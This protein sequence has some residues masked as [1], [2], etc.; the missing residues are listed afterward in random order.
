MSMW[1]EPQALV[2][3]SQSPAGCALLEAAGIPLE[4]RPAQL[5]EGT[6]ERQHRDAGAGDL[7][8]LLARAKAAAV[9]PMMPGCL[10]LGADQVLGLDEKRFS[11]PVDRGAARDQLR[12]LRGRT[13]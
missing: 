2:L 13:H 3:A 8:A 4:V 11:K 9:Q 12:A 6:I 7:A 10:V 5:D 1:L